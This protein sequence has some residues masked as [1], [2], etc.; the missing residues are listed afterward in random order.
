MDEEDQVLV[1]ETLRGRLDAFG[2]LVQRYGG[3][4]HALILARVRRPEEAEDLVQQAFCTAFEALPELRQPSRFAPWLARI[5]RTTVLRWAR[6]EACRARAEQES[7]G[8][9][10]APQAPPDAAVEGHERLQA[11]WQVLD[12]LPEGARQIVVLHHLEGCSHREVARFL[13]LSVPTVRWR[14]HRAERQ[15]SR[16]VLHLLG[17]S[18]RARRADR[19]RLCRRVLAGL[20]VGAALAPRSQ[21]LPLAAGSAHP[22]AALLHLSAPLLVGLGVVGAVVSLRGGD[23]TASSR[24]EAVPL[25]P[26]PA[27]PEGIR[28]QI[29]PQ[30]ALDRISEAAAGQAMRRGQRAADT[31]AAQAAVPVPGHMREAVSDTGEAWSPPPPPPS[32]AA[33]RRA[34]AD[35]PA[36]PPV[37]QALPPESL[38]SGDLLPPGEKPAIRVAEP[39]R[40]SPCAGPAVA[41]PQRPSR[42][43]GPVLVTVVQYAGAVRDVDVFPHAVPRLLDFLRKQTNVSMQLSPRWLALDRPEI[44]ESAL[45]YLT[46]N[47]AVLQLSE[48]EKC[49]LGAY[50]RAG[51]LLFAD[52]VRP[53]S[54]RER[55]LVP[56]DAGQPGTA[57][58][59]QLKALLR[60]P[61]VLGDA[62][63]TWET[64]PLD[65]PVYS[66]FFELAVLPPRGG[67]PRAAV[68]DLE[69]L[70][71]HGRTAVILSDLNI[72]LYWAEP[73]VARGFHP[74]AGLHFGVNLLVYA[75]TAQR[76]R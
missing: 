11:L 68:K 56:A 37:A 57:F 6:R 25:E 51:G 54:P 41:E 36:V 58:D 20:A 28:V 31:A 1:A 16:Q 8:W 52:D 42:S 43:A 60:D 71:V 23:G 75:V 30:V 13:G 67:A 40:E 3:L 10:P 21:A 33:L 72:S 44:Q 4:V 55:D 32:A 70:E 26:T 19:Q 24:P 35:T 59:R 22:L 9:L 34:A 53:A 64:V 15:L 49:G 2:L 17:E 47:S 38:E 74:E 76:S 14:L 48:A 27:R 50:L 61:L 12:G 7:Q 29:A 66:C 5:A 63:G 62:G 69:M 65:H 73:F 45:L 18:A 46:G 39:R